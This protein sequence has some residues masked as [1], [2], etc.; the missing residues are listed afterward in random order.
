MYNI[1]D[2]LNADQVGKMESPVL[3]TTIAENSI[4][5]AQQQA[6]QRRALQQRKEQ[7]RQDDIMKQLA[8]LKSGAIMPHDSPIIQKQQQDLMDWASQNGEKLWKG[9][10]ST[11]M[12]FNQKKEQFNQ[13]VDISVKKAADYTSV[14]DNVSKNQDKFLPDTY[15]KL[16]DFA[17]SENGGKVFN[18]LNY[19]T[20]RV[21][22]NK[23]GS[24]ILTERLKKPVDEVKTPIGNGGEHLVA[25]NVYTAEQASNDVKQRILN[26]H[27][28]ILN[29][30][31]EIKQNPDA[32]K[33][34]GF[35]VAN[36]ESPESRA[37]A[38]NYKSEEIGANIAFKGGKDETTIPEKTDAEQPDTTS[39][40]PSSYKI[41]TTATDASGN[42]TSVEGTVNSIA[43]ARL[44]KN[45][46]K[47]LTLNSEVR[48]F[49]GNQLPV[50]TGVFPV[51]GSDIN[52]VPVY[53][54]GSMAGDNKKDLSGNVVPSERLDEAKKAGKVE[55]KA[56]FN[57]TMKVPDVYTSDVVEGGKITHAKGEQKMF[58]AANGKE[59]P[60]T[61]DISITS[62]AHLL[63]GG[64]GKSEETVNKM[65]DIANQK[66]AELNAGGKKVTQTLNVG[67]KVGGKT[68]VKTGMHNGKRVVKFS[69]GTIE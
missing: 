29:A 58:T 3:D 39:T 35:D 69:D 8:G 63:K 6:E 49:N 62:P 50:Q 10:P 25:P 38:V 51:S 31:Y 56:M 9:D 64:L 11:T 14:V 54:S 28:A 12:Q 37:A 68:V 36:P 46:S 19:M 45:L 2:N 34:Y 66:N 23:M 52:V 13:A 30:E 27:N 7:A 67:D 18:S 48:D 21:D 15:G 16:M 4:K 60:L 32:I 43:T 61:K 26:D 42:P 65:I 53:K 55:Y 20:P 5:Y 33:K 1:Q 41:Q 57:G 22:F 17:H 47:D 24:D 44:G 40:T 59:T